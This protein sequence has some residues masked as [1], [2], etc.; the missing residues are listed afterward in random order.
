M[1]NCKKTNKAGEFR[2]QKVEMFFANE[3]LHYLLA[4][5]SYGAMYSDRVNLGTDDFNFD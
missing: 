1:G 3:A 4:G 5:S 2:P